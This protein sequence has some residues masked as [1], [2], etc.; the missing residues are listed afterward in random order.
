MKYL[1]LLS[2]SL[3]FIAAILGFAV[4]GGATA[5]IFKYSFFGLFILAMVSM[6]FRPKVIKPVPSSFAASFPSEPKPEAE[7]S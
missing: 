7:Q 4:F 6:F 3:S 5:A 2:I 1:F